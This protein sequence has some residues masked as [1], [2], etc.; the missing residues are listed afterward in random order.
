MPGLRLA[1]IPFAVAFAAVLGE[2]RPAFGQCRLCETPE[3]AAPEEGAPAPLEISVDTDLDFD[4]LLL[5]SSGAGTARLAPDGSRLA[6]GAIASIGG[7]AVVARVVVRGEPGR[8]VSIDLPDRV[9]LAGMK[10]GRLVI[11]RLIHDLPEDPA[12]DSRGLLEFA[13]GGELSLDGEADGEYRGSVPVA[14]DYL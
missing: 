7:R 1:L 5:A 9:E 3:R 14:V 2:P 12:L 6:T 8:A 13:I 11:E 4:R 10:G